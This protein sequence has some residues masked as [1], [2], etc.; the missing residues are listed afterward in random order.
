MR[1]NLAAV[2]DLENDFNFH[3]I[4]GCDGVNY[5]TSTVV[6]STWSW[7]VTMVAPPWGGPFQLQNTTKQASVRPIRKF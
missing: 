4:G 3:N 1:V 2:G 6:S 7:A 5:W